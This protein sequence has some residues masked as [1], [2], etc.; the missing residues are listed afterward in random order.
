MTRLLVSVRSA[1]EA[2]AALAGGADLIDIKEPAR[3]ALGAADRATWLAVQDAIARR[4]PLSAALGELLELPPLEFEGCHFRWVKAGLAGCASHGDWRE[5]LQRLRLSLPA[6]TELVAVIYAD[7]ERAAAPTPEQIVT[8]A[9]D[10]GLRT[11]LIDTFDKSRGDVWTALAS[12]ELA[13][14]LATAKSHGLRVALAGSI[15]AGNFPRALQLA[16]DWV[17]VRG[18]ACLGGRTGTVTAE[19]V[20]TLK[21]HL[22]RVPLLAC[23]AVPN[24]G[25]ACPSGTA[26]QASSGTL[27]R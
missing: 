2:L 15:D 26:G 21:D 4:A 23:P 8:A 27:N 5:R 25:G 17:A 20:A 10:L 1:E 16:P 14:L 18:A 7:A 22:T 12:D 11:L 9:I 19:R 6:E 24:F 3:G 13:A